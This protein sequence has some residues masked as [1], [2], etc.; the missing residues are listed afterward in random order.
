M[1]SRRK[2]ELGLQDAEADKTPFLRS[3]SFQLFRRQAKSLG[4]RF[5]P[6]I[7][8]RA[9]LNSD[10]TSL[11]LGWIDFDASFSLNGSPAR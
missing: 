6:N 9:R 4:V 10:F 1:G 11:M 5:G 8:F 7:I 3:Y 2:A